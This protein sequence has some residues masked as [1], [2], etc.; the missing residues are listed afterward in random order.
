V[1]HALPVQVEGTTG[2][3]VAVEEAGRVVAE[4]V[5]QATAAVEEAGQAVADGDRFKLPMN[6]SRRTTAPSRVTILLDNPTEKGSLLVF[7]H[8]RQRFNKQ[9]TVVSNLTA[10]SNHANSSFF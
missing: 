1:R 3:M 7:D 10:G 9:R 2:P 8:I 6:L 5:N 4:E